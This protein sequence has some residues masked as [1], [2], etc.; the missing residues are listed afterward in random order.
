MAFE[1]IRTGARFIVLKIDDGGKYNT[2]SKYDYNIVP[3]GNGIIPRP[4]T[5][6][7]QADRCV[8]LIT[9]LYP[10]M[11][12]ELKITGAG[13][14]QAISF[15]T[16]HETATLDVREFGALADGHHD[17]T[18]AIQTAINVCPEGGRVLIPSGSYSV[19]ALFIKGNINI[20]LAESAQLIGTKDKSKL[21][22]LPGIV[23]S[24]DE[25]DEYNF[26]SWEGNPLRQYA[27]MISGFDAHGCN[28]YGHGTL[29][30]NAGFEDWWKID[31]EHFTVA[32][33]NMFF[34][35]K[36][37]DIMLAGLT[38]KDSPCWTLHPYFSKNIDIIDV[39]INN[40]WNSPNTDGF[41]PES[42]TGMNVL[43]VHFSLGDDCIAIKSGKIYMGRKHKLPSSDMLV[44]HCL[45]ESGHGAV[46][47]GSEIA[48]GVNN[49]KVRDCLFHNTD[50]GLRIK[51]RRG[52]GKDSVLDN[53]VFENIEMDHVLTPFVVNSF[54]FC[55]PDGKTDYVQSRHAL[56]V[57][58]RTPSIGHLVFRNINAVDTEYAAGYYLGLPESPIEEI[59][60]ENV[61]VR[62]KEDAGAGQP[63]MSN[64]VPD[65]SKA[66][67]YAENVKNLILNNVDINGQDGDV[68]IRKG[69]MSNG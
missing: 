59:L 53:I 37:S 61:K 42:C 46:T 21:P 47:V 31:K 67:I 11:D 64:G 35:N 49:V 28:I 68:L 55:D 18:M 50:R 3:K 23:R 60:M 48:G 13:S 52:R 45:M 66:G 25:K 9:G 34:V 39:T 32:R 29:N 17:D 22:I 7:G 16:L 54:Y 33:P 8:S 27:S 12:Y 56:E 14:E 43:G 69:I 5:V 44:A 1:V 26:A 51:T 19:T 4:E 38:I 40:P 2:I 6:S 36:C 41:D 20:E 57:D 30:G 10:D 62:Y 63:A 58:D 15:R 24:Y 65:T